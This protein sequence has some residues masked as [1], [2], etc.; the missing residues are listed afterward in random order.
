MSAIWRRDLLLEARP[1]THSRSFPAGLLASLAIVVASGCTSI[2]VD[3][4]Q[5]A[6]LDCAKIHTYAFAPRPAMSGTTAADEQVLDRAR[7][8]ADARLR[9]IGW[10]RAER[11]AADVLVSYRLGVEVKARTKDPYYA[12]FYLAERYEEGQLTIALSDPHTQ[13]TLWSGT[14]HHPLRVVSRGY[15]T[16]GLT[17]KDADEERDWRID[18]MVTQILDALPR[19]KANG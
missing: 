8:A 6:P 16:L 13:R 15:G 10:Q 11:S 17:W 3:S 9:A 7:D 12:P 19:G 4:A 1:E 18:E 14:G 2:A 5:P